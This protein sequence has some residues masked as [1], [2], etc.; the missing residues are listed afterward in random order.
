M[1]V[2]IVQTDIRKHPIKEDSC[3]LTEVHEILENKM[4]EILDE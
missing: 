3:L 1:I 2:F 4:L